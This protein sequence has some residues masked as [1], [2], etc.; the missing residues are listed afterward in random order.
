MAG[1]RKKAEAEILK[2]ITQL[3]QGSVNAEIYKEL[4]AEMSNAEFDKWM[5]NLESGEEILSFFAPNGSKVKLTSANCKKVGDSLGVKFFQRCILTDP[6]TKEEFLTPEE[7][8]VLEVPV[9]RQS[10]HL[11][12]KQSIAE[13]DKVIDAMTGQVTGES[14]TRSISLPEILALESK[15]LDMTLLEF[16]KVR[17]GDDKSLTHMKD[18]IR[19][20]GGY[21]VGSTLE[22]GSKPTATE[23]LRALLLAL[24]IDNTI[25]KQ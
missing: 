3:E 7:Y 24:H 4:F 21:N 11:I 8:L 6:E 16:I 12:K 1:N 2:Y 17:G 23:T 19:Q 15:G 14:K 20:T 25:G 10:Q 13:G 18:S 22:L 9:R 5:K